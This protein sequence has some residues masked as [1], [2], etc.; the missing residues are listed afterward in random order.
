MIGTANQTKVD[1]WEGKIAEVLGVKRK[2]YESPWVIGGGAAA[3]ATIG[4]IVAVK[5]EK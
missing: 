3:V 1:T 4:I 5:K 2:W